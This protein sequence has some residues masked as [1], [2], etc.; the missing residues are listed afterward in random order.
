M[1]RQKA[2][3]VL[4]HMES[5]IGKL[6][7]SVAKHEKSEETKTADCVVILPASSRDIGEPISSTHAEENKTNRK[8][9]LKI[10]L[11]IRFLARQGTALQGKLTGGNLHQLLDTQK[12]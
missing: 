9:L 2:I 1:K 4:Q 10:L 11:G 3:L 12:R 7:L 8:L 6:P 5:Q